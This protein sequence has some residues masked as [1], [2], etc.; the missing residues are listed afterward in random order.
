MA[1]KVIGLACDIRFTS[2]IKE[3]T[4]E[5]ALQLETSLGVSLRFECVLVEPS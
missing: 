3:S 2:E 5:T 4:V 1:P